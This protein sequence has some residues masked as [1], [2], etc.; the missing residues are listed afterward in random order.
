MAKEPTPA[1]LRAEARAVKNYLES[2]QSGRGSQGTNPAR[3][4]ERLERAQTSLASETNVL[5]R[6]EIVQSIHDLEDAIKR[7]GR[8]GE[9]V[10]LEAE[11]VKYG[12]R[13]SE[14]K[15][16]EWAAWRSMGVPAAVLTKAGVPRTRRA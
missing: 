5:R 1:D 11:F 9:G 7:S 13:Y 3:L 8:G 6:A 10:D 2:L 4:K 15:G 16:L 14:R 12:A